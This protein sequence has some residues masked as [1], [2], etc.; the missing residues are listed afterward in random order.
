MTK[1]R[2]SVKRTREI[3]VSP[4]GITKEAQL[5]WIALAKLAQT[6]KRPAAL[7]NWQAD[8]QTV[9]AVLGC[10]VPTALA[11]QQK[12]MDRGLDPEASAQ[13][14]VTGAMA[15]KNVLDRKLGRPVERVQ[16]LGHVVIEFAGLDP[17]KLP[18]ARPED[19]T[20][21]V[22]VAPIDDGEG[23]E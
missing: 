10:M 21:V 5:R 16:T 7:D 6:G 12:A 11:M 13:D 1:R 20:E 19:A 4:N 3:A 8:P 22:E 18:D 14:V 2:Q 15:A 17:S 9:D 23:E